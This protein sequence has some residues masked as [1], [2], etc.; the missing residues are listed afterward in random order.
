MPLAH[1]AGGEIVCPLNDYAVDEYQSDV[2]GPRPAVLSFE[3]APPDVTPSL[4][5]FMD[6]RHWYYRRPQSLTG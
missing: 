6:V 4:D 5:V 3:P 2:R 1:G